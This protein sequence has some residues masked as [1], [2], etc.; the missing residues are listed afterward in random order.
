[1]PIADPA[2]GL[3][4]TQ[5]GWSALL[6]QRPPPQP[7]LAKG[8]W[9]AAGETGGFRH[10]TSRAGQ[11][12]RGGVRQLRLGVESLTRLRR[13]LPLAREPVQLATSRGLPITQPGH[14]APLCQPPIPTRLSSL[15][16]T[17]TRR[18]TEGADR[19]PTPGAHTHPTRARSPATAAPPPTKK[20]PS[21]E[22][23]G[24]EGTFTPPPPG[25]TGHGTARC[26]PRPFA[27]APGGCRFP[28]C[29]PCPSPG[30]DP[31]RLWCS[32]GGQ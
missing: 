10:P 7:A 1:M 5:V 16:G 20:A 22:G 3:P 2:R 15:E 9:L 30:C 21:S 23:A 4:I 14:A 31:P 27:A 11:P 29:G 26:T 18:V 19:C 28:R 32:A 13:E 6:R 8:G 12:R 24:N 25:R 17:V